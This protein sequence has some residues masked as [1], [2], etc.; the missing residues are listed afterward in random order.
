MYTNSE[1]ALA[2]DEIIGMKAAAAE[3]ARHGCRI[4]ATLGENIM[5]T[6]DIDPADF[7]RCSPAGILGWLGY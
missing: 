7:I 6:N 3:L 5:V 2:D 1:D 4:L